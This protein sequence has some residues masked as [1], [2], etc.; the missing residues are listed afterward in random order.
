MENFESLEASPVTL[1]ALSQQYPELWQKTRN[2]AEVA[3]RSRNPENVFE[4]VTSHAA[5]ANSWMNQWGASGR[6]SQIRNEVESHVVQSKMAKLILD[7]YLHALLEVQDE[8]AKLSLFQKIALDRLCF[9]KNGYRKPVPGF[10]FDLIYKR[11][12]ARGRF[13]SLLHQKGIY[14]LFSQTF[15]QRLKRVIGG[16]SCLEVGAG[17]GCL[18][19]SLQNLGVKVRATDNHSWTHRIQFPTYVESMCAK[20]AV[21]TYQAP[22]VICSWP[23][24]GNSFEAHILKS[25]HLEKYVVVLSKSEFASGNWNA[26]RSQKRF[27][28]NEVHELSKEILPAESQSRCYVFNRK[29]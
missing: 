25:P 15:F 5:R 29:I 12:R 3:L 22:V 4:F 28:M 14:C 2:A 20:T 10:W 21:D 6:N 17:D 16:A 7:E 19:K 1:E 13:I 18:S 9:D 24:P 26:Y 8:N 27:E 23:P 11:V